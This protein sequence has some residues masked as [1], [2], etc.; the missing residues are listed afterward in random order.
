MRQKIII[1]FII[2]IC[3]C[4]VP[5]AIVRV[6]L[7][8]HSFWGGGKVDFFTCFVCQVWRVS[9][10]CK[11]VGC[12]VSCVTRCMP[13]II[14]VTRRKENLLVWGLL[15]CKWIFS[16]TARQMALRQKTVTGHVKLNKYRSVLSHLDH[17]LWLS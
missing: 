6:S 12:L 4:K 9:V 14:I 3:T 5:Y 8:W 11:Y 10:L 17:K 7:Q 15:C 16:H 1:H 2:R 13:A